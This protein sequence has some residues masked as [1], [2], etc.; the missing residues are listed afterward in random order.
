MHQRFL[1]QNLDLPF[2][3]TL[4]SIHRSSLEHQSGLNSLRLLERKAKVK[5][6]TEY[7]SGSCCHRTFSSTSGSEGKASSLSTTLVLA[8]SA[9]TLVSIYLPNLPAPPNLVF[10]ST[11]PFSVPVSTFTTACCTLGTL[12][13]N[14]SCILPVIIIHFAHILS[15]LL[16]I[17]II[18]RSFSVSAAKAFRFFMLLTPVSQ[19]SPHY[20]NICCFVARSSHGHRCSYLLLQYISKP[21]TPHWQTTRKRQSEVPCISLPDTIP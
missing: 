4:A 18:T 1:F 20:F 17:S 9:F 14:C 2:I 19:C 21:L 13:A 3:A 8:F 10:L 6:N 5:K 15:T 16:L 7:G 11:S 12:L